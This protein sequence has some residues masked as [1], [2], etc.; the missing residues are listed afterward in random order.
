ML[1]AVDDPEY[2]F[3]GYRGSLVAVAMLSKNRILHVIT[4]N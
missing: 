4:E 2:I 3:R 1:D